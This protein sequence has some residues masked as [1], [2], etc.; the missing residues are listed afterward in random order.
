MKYAIHI[1]T[2]SSIFQDSSEKS[3]QTSQL[4]FGE[5]C[6]IKSERDHFFYVEN[7]HDKH[8]GWVLKDSFLILENKEA[9][10]LREQELLRVCMPLVDVFNLRDKTV[11]RLPAGSIIPNYNPDSNKFVIEDLEFQIHSSFI[12][13]LPHGNMDGIVETA[14]SFQNTPFMYG[15]KSVL[16][17]DKAGFIQLIFNLCGYSMPRGIQ[18]QAKIGVPVYSTKQFRKGDLLFIGDDNNYTNVLVY[19]NDNKFI[20]VDSKVRI[21][22]LEEI[23]IGTTNYIIRR[24]V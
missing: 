1:N 17:V 22:A 12:T 15:G 9:E 18:D 24:L 13:Y 7:I 20:G 4:L 2:L 16:G 6:L 3:K 21:I 14:L 8:C 10:K 19:W 23:D 5:L 11:L